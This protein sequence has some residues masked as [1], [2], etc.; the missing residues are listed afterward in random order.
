MADVIVNSVLI[1]LRH[2]VHEAGK[3][4]TYDA[5]TQEWVIDADG[6]P[7]PLAEKGPFTPQALDAKGLTLPNMMAAATQAAVRDLADANKRIAD[8]TKT[9][10]ASQLELGGIIAEVDQKLA[11]EQAAH[12]ETRSTLAA[13]KAELDALP[14]KPL[15]NAL[16]FGILGN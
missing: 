15:L 7:A 11:K 12:S 16:T 1:R 14:E 3:P 6:V 8:L 5:T 10:T 2:P 9:V 13:V 4:S